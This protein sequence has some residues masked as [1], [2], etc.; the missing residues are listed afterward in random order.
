MAIQDEQD[1]RLARLAGKA[2]RVLV[3]AP[4]SGLGTLRR[5]PDLKWRQSMDDIAEKTLLQ[6]RILSAASRLV[7]SR[8]TSYNVCYT[9]LLRL[10]PSISRVVT[11]RQSFL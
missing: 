11:W 7:K 4:C 10:L 6:G 9:K 5:S 3:D 2:D 1:K 8:I